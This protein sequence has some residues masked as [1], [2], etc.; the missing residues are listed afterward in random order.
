MTAL[1]TTQD[2]GYGGMPVSDTAL[3]WILAVLVIAQ[4]ISHIES[5]FAAST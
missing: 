1:T 3:G 4:L 2:A 5:A